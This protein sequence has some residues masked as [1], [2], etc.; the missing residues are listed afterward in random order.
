MVVFVCI[1]LYDNLKV[2]YPNFQSLQ[3]FKF[4]TCIIDWQSEFSS[5]SQSIYQFTNRLL[6]IRYFF[7]ISMRNYNIIVK[8][9]NRTW[10]NS[11]RISSHGYLVS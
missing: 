2:L 6:N 8:Q 4:F 10:S 9:T 3:T 1:R 11:F 5:L 7:P